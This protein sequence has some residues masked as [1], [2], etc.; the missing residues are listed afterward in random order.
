MVLK[1]L[2]EI[3][4]DRTVGDLTPGSE[5]FHLAIRAA[6]KELVTTP[7]EAT[8]AWFNLGRMYEEVGNFGLAADAFMKHGGGA[9][10]TQR[11]AVAFLKS[12][13]ERD[14]INLYL[15]RHADN[16]EIFEVLGDEGA[17][18]TRDDYQRVVFSLVNSRRVHEAKE[19][20]F[21]YGNYSLDSVS[22]LVWN[23]VD[24]SE[25]DIEEVIR[26][27]RG[28]EYEE[29]ATTAKLRGV[30]EL[31]LRII[32]GLNAPL[33]KSY[34]LFGS[35]VPFIQISSH[36]SEGQITDFVEGEVEDAVKRSGPMAG[37]LVAERY[38]QGDRASELYAQAQEERPD[39]LTKAEALRGVGDQEGFLG[40]VYQLVFGLE[41]RGLD[42]AADSI[43]TYYGLKDDPADE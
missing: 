11:A 23:N 42:L 33:A 1:P 35:S 10:E 21:G 20:V 24:L 4:G 30:T 7:D 43:R 29:I 39:P 38:D 2:E 18:F 5:D 31:G 26:A 22:L 13:R 14:A 3:L 25:G 6:R 12:G 8:L 19:L 37:A 9:E 27:S 36:Y 16:M 41:A 34:E 40:E 17:E 28:L 32:V 15:T